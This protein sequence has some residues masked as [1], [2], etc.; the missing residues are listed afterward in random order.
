MCGPATCDALTVEDGESGRDFSKDLPESGIG[1]LE[2]E[3]VE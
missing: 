3:L 2:R 1:V